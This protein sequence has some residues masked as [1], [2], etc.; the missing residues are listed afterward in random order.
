MKNV[1]FLAGTLFAVMHCAYAQSSPT[2][3]APIQDRTYKL[4][5]EDENWS[6][7]QNPG[8]RQDFWD[9]IKYIPLRKDRDDWYVT[10]GGEVRE[11]WEQIG[12]DNWGQQPYQN[13]YLNERYV[14]FSD[15]HYG[16]HVRTFLDLKSGLNSFRR[17]GPRPIDEKKLDFQSGFLELSAGSPSK[18]IQVRVGR[19][20]LEYGSGRVVDVREGPNVRLSFDGVLVKSKI[21]A[22]Q[23][24]GFAVRPDRD[25]PGFFDNVPNHSVGFWGVYAARYSPSKSSVELY[26]LGLD[27]KSATFER[28]TAHEVRHSIGARIARPVA[29]TRAGWDFDD[30]GLYQFGAFGSGNIRA[31]TVG[32]ETG[33][34][35]PNAPLK[36]RFSVKADIS[37]GNHQ[38]SSALGTFNPIFPKGNYFGVLATTGPGPINFVDIHPHVETALPHNVSASFDWIVQWRESL[39]DGVYSVPGNLIVAS[40]GSKARYVGNRPGTEIKWQANRHLWF[41]ADYGVFYA[42]QFLK[43]AGPGRNLNYWA[44]WS[45]YKF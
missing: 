36:P 25:N 35:F 20:E 33:Y 2:T 22:W 13:G 5:R 10:L 7:L 19:H 38:G 45:G 40:G 21:D 23:V 30:E 34:R 8:L 27:R 32:T 31:W 39:D 6:F 37:S 43:D 28:G 4:L 11:V 12:N 9:P 44:L 15:L 3:T 26:Y 16:K 18:S 17:G 41:Q 14:F 29:T 24:D 42:G 1:F